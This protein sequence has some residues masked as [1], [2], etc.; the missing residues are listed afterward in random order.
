MRR[1]L[2]R[3]IVGVFFP[4]IL[5]VFFSAACIPSQA[6]A[7]KVRKAH[8][9]EKFPIKDMKDVIWKF[10]ENKAF[11]SHALVLKPGRTNVRVKP[12]SVVLK[13]AKKLH[14]EVAQGSDVGL[15]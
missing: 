2:S 7:Q 5:S 13:K 15:S 12:Y 1:S 3:P 14:L 6:P 11:P 4:H 9:K 8:V 10:D